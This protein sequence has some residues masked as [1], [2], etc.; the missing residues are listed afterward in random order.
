VAVLRLHVG[1]AHVRSIGLILLDFSREEGKKNG[2]REYHS[3]GSQRR[4]I[5]GQI[6]VEAQ[7][8]SMLLADRTG[9]PAY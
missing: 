7:L 9:S 6:S 4:A 8:I 5:G 2:K 1:V 3:G